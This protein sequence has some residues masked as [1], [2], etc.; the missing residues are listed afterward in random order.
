M[1]EVKWEEFFNYYHDI[2]CSIDLDV[3]FD[4]MMRQAWKLWKK[5]ERPRKRL[6]TDHFFLEWKTPQPWQMITTT[7]HPQIYD[8]IPSLIIH[9]DFCFIYDCSSNSS[10]T[11]FS[12]IYSDWFFQFFISALFFYTF[13]FIPFIISCSIFRFS[14]EIVLREWANHRMDPFTRSLWLA[15]VVSENQ[16][17]KGSKYSSILIRLLKEVCIRAQE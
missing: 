3:Y 1:K 8:F 11:S 9:P 17:W 16:L 14:E 10:N 5:K 7:P 4:V 6:F 13:N 12:S 15:M 2:S